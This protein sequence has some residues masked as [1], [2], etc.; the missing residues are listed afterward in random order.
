M[1]FASISVYLQHVKKEN[2][3]GFQI[4]LVHFSTGHRPVARSGLS[5]LR[6]GCHARATD[7]DS[8]STD[9][10]ASPIDAHSCTAHHYSYAGAANSY[11][12]SQSACGRR[13]LQKLPRRGA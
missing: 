10:D 5:R 12:Y 2:P 1:W 11:C 7:A 4:Q 3:D 13:R 8:C 6:T 9:I